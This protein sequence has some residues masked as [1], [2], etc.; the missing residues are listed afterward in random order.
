MT[1]TSSTVL[2]D[3]PRVPELMPS[4]PLR[5]RMQAEFVEMPG[6]VLTLPQAARLWGVTALQAQN[7]LTQL[8]VD[9]FLAFDPHGTY[10]RRGACPRC[11]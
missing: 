6:L 8:V 11:S 9:G 7:A 3:R 5:R 4:G 2:E 1:T 10:R